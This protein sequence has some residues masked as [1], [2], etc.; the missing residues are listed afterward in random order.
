MFGAQVEQREDEDTGG[1]SGYGARCDFCASIMIFCGNLTTQKCV[2]CASPIHIE[3]VA[4][5]ENRIPVDAVLPFGISLGRARKAVGSW[6]EGLWFAP[7]DFRKSDVPDRIRGVYQPYWTFDAMIF[8]RDSGERGTIRERTVW[9]DGRDERRRTIRWR[10]ASG[11]FQRLFDDRPVSADRSFP[12]EILD[13]LEPWPFQKCVSHA[14]DL[15]AGYV[16]KT[17]GV[18]L[19]EGFK[20]ARQRIEDELHSTAKR[21]IGRDQQ[22]IHLIST[23]WDALPYEHVLLPV[24]FLVMQHRGRAYQLVVNAA[25]GEVQGNDRGAGARSRGSVWLWPSRQRSDGSGIR[26]GSEGASIAFMLLAASHPTFERFQFEGLGGGRAALDA[27]ATSHA[28]L[29]VQMGSPVFESER[30]RICGA[31]VDASTAFRA[32]EGD[33]VLLDESHPTQ[34]PGRRTRH[35][36]R[37]F[38]AGGRAGE[39]LTLVASPILR[40]QHRR[41]RERARLLVE[42]MDRIMGAGFGAGAAARAL[43]EEGGFGAGPRRAAARRKATIHT[44]SSRPRGD[45]ECPAE[46]IAHQG[47]A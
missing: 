40:N 8:T 5:A 43:R 19:D 34:R 26:V 27:E 15:L 33:A 30:G 37:R 1:A 32:H 47:S 36:E 24:W 46:E 45:I 12:R 38:R 29:C 39:I 35:L 16:A 28:E 22:R 10:P 41:A 23:R 17:Y 2:Y 7:N 20:I 42:M 11:S 6:L 4:R 9:V 13:G 18:P 31:G 25:T 21:D 3:P 44:G 14:P